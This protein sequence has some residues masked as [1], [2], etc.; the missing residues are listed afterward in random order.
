MSL[1]LT[2]KY[3][4]RAGKRVG[5]TVCAL[6]VTTLSKASLISDCQRSPLSIELGIAQVP[7]YPPQVW[8]P[9]PQTNRQRQIDR[10]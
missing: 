8:G 6:H 3:G 1:F 10:Y 7:L 9:P 5:D 2:L 4:L